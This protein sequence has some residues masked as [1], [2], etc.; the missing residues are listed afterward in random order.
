[1]L[2]DS[3]LALDE[4]LQFRRRYQGP[5]PGRFPFEAPGREGAHETLLDDEQAGPLGERSEGVQEPVQNLS[6]GRCGIQE[7]EA[8]PQFLVAAGRRLRG[9]GRRG[10]ASQEFGIGLP[11]GD[12]LAEGQRHLLAEGLVALQEPRSERGKKIGGRAWVHG[13]ARKRFYER[14]L[15][16][17]GRRKRVIPSGRNG[18]VRMNPV[19][20]KH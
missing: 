20:S 3:E 8:E 13:R 4:G 5:L 14:S 18:S 15:F 6:L 1:M 12:I 16:A 19:G 7:I 9:R 11:S 2:D 10:E 17:L